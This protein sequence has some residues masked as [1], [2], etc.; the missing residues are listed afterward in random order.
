MILYTGVHLKAGR[1]QKSPY[2]TVIL[3]AVISVYI[4]TYS[5]VLS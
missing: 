1:W 2:I 5:P 4:C 3:L